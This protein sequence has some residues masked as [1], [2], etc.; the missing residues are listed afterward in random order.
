MSLSREDILAVYEEGPEAVVAL[1]QTLCSITDKQSARIA[2]L[3]E[4]VKS[5]ED[6]INKNSRNSSKPPSTDTFRKI[7]G[8]RK[9]SGKSVGGQKG[10]KGYT[11]EMAE[12]PD[13]EIVHQVTKCEFC[14]LSLR[15]EDAMKYERRQVFDLP[16]IK[17][18]VFEHQVE[19]KICP[20]CG[21]LNKAT[22]PKEVAYPVQ[23]GTRLRSVAV[24]LNQ[25]Q[26]VPFDRLSETFNDLFNHRLSQSTLIDANHACYDILEPVEEAIKQ[27]IIA[28]PVICLDETGMRIEG[29][30]KWCHVVSTENLTY[31][32][33]NSHRGSEAN[34][35][36]GILPVYSGTA[37]H[38]GW[39]S[40]FKFNC[41]HALCNSHH[42]RDLTFIHEEE[43][44]NWAKDLIDQLI[45]IKT[46]VDRRRPIHFKLDLAEI[47]DFEERYDHIIERAKLEN[48]PPIASNSQGQIRKRGKMKKTKAQNLLERL[49]KY[50]REVLAFMYDFEI[51]FDNNQAERDLRMMKVQQK[52][53]GNF[54]SWDGAR[55]FCRIRGYISTVKKNSISVIDAIQGAFEGNPFIPERTLIAV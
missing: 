5:L 48:P 7:K 31:Y 1:V 3:E 17:V 47:E 35:D 8:Q 42:L 6:Q 13:H 2:E 28:S 20:N 16:P 18:E 32:A 25:Y 11:L 19:S 50:R 40:Y 36:M 55:I 39:S 45:S 27:Q 37:M 26:L 44:Q 33:A 29:K 41:K 15:D 46:A 38:D 14:G 22:F 23:Y 9:P 10:H 54:R 4:R 34:E 24:Y 12:K 30:R 53:S 49:Q 43:K 21:C 51:P 52:I